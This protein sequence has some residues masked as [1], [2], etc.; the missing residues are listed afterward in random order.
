M[1]R[2]HEQARRLNSIDQALRPAGSCLAMQAWPAW[3][4]WLEAVA[5]CQTADQREAHAISGFVKLSTGVK[6]CSSASTQASDGT[7]GNP[8]VAIA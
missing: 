2:L 7:T 6:E 3:R 4:H 8:H 5:A 1:R